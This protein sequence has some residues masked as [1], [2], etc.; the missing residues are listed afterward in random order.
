VFEMPL[1]GWSSAIENSQIVSS[2]GSFNDSFGYSVAAADGVALIGAP[3]HAGQGAAYVFS[4]VPL[5]APE[6]GRCVSAQAVKEGKKTV[7]H[8]NFTST[9][10]LVK[11]EAGSGRYDWVPGLAKDGFTTQA[12]GPI[13]LE[14]IAKVKVTCEGESGTGRFD[15]SRTVAGVILHFNSCESSGHKCTTSGHAEGELATSTLEGRIGW[16]VKASKKVALDL[17]PAGSA[18]S[19]L[20]YQ[21]AGAAPSSVGGSVLVPVVEDKMVA[22]APLKFKAAKG[23]QK[24]EAFE[25]DATDVLLSSLGGG[26]F[27]QTGLR[28]TMTEVGE[29]AMEVNTAV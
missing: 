28:V 14:T 18:V 19:F 2:D 13:T 8:G 4:G 15:G 27:E 24:P 21:C 11:S 25:G 9:K 10:C 3:R 6:Y 7:Y 22:S 1:P 16:E 29:E 26:V 5:E 20:E 23:R 17:R 12:E